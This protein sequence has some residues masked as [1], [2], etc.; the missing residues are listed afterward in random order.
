MPN[1]LEKIARENFRTSGYLSH[2]RRERGSS[3]TYSAPPRITFY[4]ANTVDDVIH[5]R[6]RA[7]Q[8]QTSKPSFIQTLLNALL[9]R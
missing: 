2:P 7:L 6:Q 4:S 1:T 9:Q 8:R 5:R 3:W